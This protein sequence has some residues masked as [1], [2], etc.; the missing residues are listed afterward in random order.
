MPSTNTRAT[1][2]LDT[3]LSLDGG[4][5]TAIVTG[6]ERWTRAELDHC[7]SAL[8]ATLSAD[9]V[10]RGDR[11]ALVSKD[12]ITVLAM[13]LA[14][15]RLGAVTVPINWRS[16]P[17]DAARVIADADPILALG[18]EDLA[19][20]AQVGA[21]ALPLGRRRFSAWV[22]GRDPIGASG[23]Q[24]PDRPA[25]LIY[26]SGTSG[27]PK[28]VVLTADNLAHKVIG[29][30]DDWGVRATSVSLLATPL[31]HIG[32]L[33]WALVALAARAPLIVPDPARGRTLRSTIEEHQVTHA[34][35]VPKLLTDL[36]Q[37]HAS[38]TGPPSPIEMVLCGAAPVSIALQRQAIDVLGCRL[39][40]V[41]G[42][43]ETT[44]SVTQLDVARAI[45][46]PDP[47]QALASCGTPFPWVGLDIRDPHD[48]SP[49]PPG[50]HGEIWISSAQ[51]CAGYWR[52]P[53]ASAEL[54]VNGWLRTGDAGH[55]DEDG[56]LHITDRL[57]DVIISGGENIYS[58]EVERALQ[59]MPAV[60][61]AAVV[62]RPDHEWGETVVAVV[63][64]HD[65]A[66]LDLTEVA[67]HVGR[68]IG[69]FKR[70]RDLVV[71]DELPRN[72]TG[73]ILKA[74]VRRMVS[75]HQKGTA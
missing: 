20:T 69:R 9:G 28:G 21:V 43:T 30:Q 16:S 73:K 52:R 22:D 58:V 15:L 57:K 44:G 13:M 14:A 47:D 72:A 10:D 17:Q 70:P 5:Q 59:S 50:E 61:D 55:L 26:T 46:G 35:L 54:Q 39:L 62:G 12:P 74:E 2:D 11:V 65:D 29:T 27:D 75:T 45:A 6:E 18:D 8:A 40:Q 71:V 67:D 24:D 36:V 4:T 32:G 66:A 64:L 41:Y 1:P 63:E 56:R 37:D 3:L 7:V 60:R 68:Q 49:L 31:F 33:S 42:L 48:A 38:R 25:V 51:N 53:T 23:A 19:T 34:F